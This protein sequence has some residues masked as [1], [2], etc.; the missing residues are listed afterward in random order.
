MTAKRSARYVALLEKF[1]R[2]ETE[3]RRAFRRYEKYREQ[4]M[5][6]EKLLDKELARCT[7]LG[8]KADWRDFGDEI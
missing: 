6:L 7:D 5:R 4:L 1:N 2:A 3:M 8:G